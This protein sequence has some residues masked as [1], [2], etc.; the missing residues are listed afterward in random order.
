MRVLDA[1]RPQRAK[2]TVRSDL[3]CAACV[4]GWLVL[5]TIRK[6][7]KRSTTRRARGSSTQHVELCTTEVPWPLHSLCVPVTLLCS[8][9]Y[10]T[11]TYLGILLLTFLL[12]A[13]LLV[14]I[15]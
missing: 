4:N 2:R 10:F 9:G 8:T 7:A 3:S 11:E 1:I 12:L 6:Q 13:S 5:G 15:E 14:G